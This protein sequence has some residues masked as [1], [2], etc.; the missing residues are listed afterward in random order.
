MNTSVFSRICISLT[1]AMCLVM[2][3][4]QSFAQEPI[5]DEPYMAPGAQYIQVDPAEAEAL[6][7][8]IVENPDLIVG[9]CEEFNIVIILDAS[10][11][12][13][14][15]A[16][17]AGQF[18]Q[19]EQ[20][21]RAAT[22]GLAQALN[23]TGGE[24]AI[25]QF[26]TSSQI[27]DVD[28]GGPGAA[29]YRL[30]ND[31]FIDDL[32][33]YLYPGGVNPPANGTSGY[34]ASGWTNWEAAFDDVIALNAIQVADLVLFLTDGN[35]TAYVFN[36]GT[37]CDGCDETTSLNQATPKADLVKTAGSHIYGI[38]VG[39]NINL[40]NIAAMTGPDEDTA[41]GNGDG[42]TPANSDYTQVSF[43]QLQN[44]FNQIAVESCNPDVELQK[45]VYLGH[46]NG[47]SFPG[48]EQVSGVPNAP[49]TY[50]FSITNDGD[51]YL[52]LVSF[53]DAD[54]GIN[55]DSPGLT[56]LSGSFPLAPASL[57]PANTINLYFESNI[58]GDLVNT[59]SVQLNPVDEFG[60][61]L[62]FADISDTDTASV[63]DLGIP[64]GT[65]VTSGPTGP[66]CPSSVQTYTA[67][68][69]GL[70]DNPV[71]HW[72]VQG[73]A[74]I[75]NDNGATL[76]VQVGTDCEDSYSVSVSIDCQG[77]IP[78]ATIHCPGVTA[79]VEDT[80]A[81]HLSANDDATVECGQDFDLVGYQAMDECGDV[82]VEIDSVFDAACGNTGVWTITY[83][84]A[85]ECGN[86]TSDTQ[87]I[88][89]V[90]T[91]P[92]TIVCAPDATV[93]CGEDTSP[94]A[95][96]KSS[97]GDA[98]GLV[99]IN[100]SDQ[101]EPACGATGVIYRTWTTTDECGNTSSCV[102]TITI[103]DTTAP[104]IDPAPA[105][106]SVD[107]TEIPDAIMLTA[108]DICDPDVAVIFDEVMVNN[109]CPYTITRTWTATDDCGNQSE[110]TQVITVND[111]IAPVFGEFDLII[112]VPCDGLD[113][114]TID[115]TDN[116]DVDLE[117]TIED[118]Q[119]SGS[120][121]GCTG[122]IERFWTA[123]DECGN[124]TT[125]IQYIYLT[126][127]EG[128]E[129]PSSLD[130]VEIGF[131]TPYARVNGTWF[132]P[133]GTSDCEVRGGLIDPSTIGTGAPEFANLNNTQV[134]TQ[135]DGSTIL[136]NIVLYNNPNVP[137]IEGQTYGYEVRCACEDGSGYSAWSG[138]TD[139]S[140]F[141]V[142][143]YNP[144]NGGE[145]TQRLSVDGFDMEFKVFPNPTDG[146]VFISATQSKEGDMF[147]ELLD[148]LGRQMS[149]ERFSGQVVERYLDLQ[150][151][152]EGVYLLRMTSADGIQTQRLEIQR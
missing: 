1:M 116:C 45:T 66:V 8:T 50:C 94:G 128:C 34:E 39:S 90:D 123:T 46:D 12:I 52:D 29:G 3:S 40:S 54:L 107:C 100:S 72:T 78:A 31:D 148:M 26:S 24:I 83:T 93:E 5:N 98:C 111:T 19:N 131:G 126:E 147:L 25:V 151:L 42:F 97:A 130:V 118:L 30:V 105:D 95:I 102:Q 80:T 14:D 16:S 81:P 2:I 22:L 132:N 134:I 27:V 138:M 7:N 143:Y 56:I 53:L 41:P 58:N 124:S 77:C 112:N 82:T 109:G 103:V 88:T 114:L 74:H 75:L 65:C 108:T 110:E 101:F 84:A 135:T 117:I 89:I 129:P 63:I 43:A 37:I 61:D 4:N 106:V 142:P 44:D 146:Q 60:N 57:A 32:S 136:F 73:N 21:V 9:P 48:I 115:V 127:P 10:G 85:D 87:T 15:D 120:V 113:D 59:A 13:D 33:D 55:Q 121:G 51:S 144:A 20:D 141:V 104:M 62:G 133:E 122:T 38:A 36:N 86:T 92:P 64:C 152:S 76:D 68:I 137:F 47:A 99:S 96:G 69:T 6:R 49:V 28:G 79:T 140:T 139:E 35:P 18:S 149:T 125:A 17:S 145:S 91:T 150:G 23:N 67:P 71:Y 119:F 70:C 11:S